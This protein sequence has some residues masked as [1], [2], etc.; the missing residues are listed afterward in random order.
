MPFS[1]YR[2]PQVPPEEGLRRGEALF[3]RLSAR[4][5]VRAFRP[6]PVPRAL[7]ERAIAIAG[8]APSGAHQ[9]PWTWVAVQNPAVKAR[10]R[11]AAEA[12]ER[13]FYEDR[14]P[15]EWLRA[16]LAIGTTWQKPYL[17]IAPWIVVLFAQRWGGDDAGG[18]RKHYYVSE[19]CGIAAGFFVTALHEMGLATLTHTPAPMRFLAEILGRPENEAPLILFP[20]GWPAEDAQVPDLHRKALADIAVFVE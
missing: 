20:V 14:A 11:E 5:S 18:R 4:R 12:E 16:L 1:P 3:E 17:E 6:D 2:P 7:I 8:T 9:Q 13:A 10:I 19:S 15:E